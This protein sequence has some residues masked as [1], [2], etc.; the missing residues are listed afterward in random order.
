MVVSG[1]SKRLYHATK[2]LT[3]GCNEYTKITT[4]VENVRGYHSTRRTQNIA[5]VPT[6]YVSKGLGF[7]RDYCTLHMNESF[8][9]T[10][11]KYTLRVYTHGDQVRCHP[12][13]AYLLSFP[14]IPWLTFVCITLHT[15]MTIVSFIIEKWKWL[16]KL[17]CVFILWNTFYLILNAYQ[18]LKILACFFYR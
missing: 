7:I 1:V 8:K 16:K 4:F 14:P 3:S 15:Y 6:S 18:I 10:F 11:T 2:K 13:L 9:N 12:S 5:L 17:A